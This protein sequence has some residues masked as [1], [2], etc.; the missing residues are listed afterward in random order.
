M[1]SPSPNLA[2]AHDVADLSILDA[3]CAVMAQRWPHGPSWLHVNTGR[4]GLPDSID[5]TV[6]RGGQ[7]FN[8]YAPTAHEAFE[9]AIARCNESFAASRDKRIAELRRQLALVEGDGASPADV[10]ERRVGA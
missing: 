10:I 3:A 9:K 4:P 2:V 7:S 1:N 5:V 8:G 6:F